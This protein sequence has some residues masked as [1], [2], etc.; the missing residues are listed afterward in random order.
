MHSVIELYRAKMIE[1]GASPSQAIAAPTFADFWY[2]APD[3]IL[4]MCLPAQEYPLSDLSDRIKFIGCLPRRAPQPHDVY[5]EWWDE[6]IANAKLPRDDGSGTQK[7]KKRKQVIFVSQGTVAMDHSQLVL[8]TF[9]AFADRADDVLVVAA[10]GARGAA[11]PADVAATLPPNARVA[12]YLPYDTML[13]EGQADVF[14]S[15]AGYGA[16]CHAVV[17]A[18]PLVL[19]GVTE[20]KTEATMR[21]T[22]AGYAVGLYTQTPTAKQVR[23]GVDTVLKDTRYKARAEEL[24]RENEEMRCLD[25]VEEF[26]REYTV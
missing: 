5:P 21:A 25:R 8:P 26:V 14:V 16:L 6:I 17:N 10:L 7:E 11:L 4:Q 2:D 15:N 20:D 24:R 22:R 18:V 12:D 3:V 19:A 23:E 13:H 9:E 1:A